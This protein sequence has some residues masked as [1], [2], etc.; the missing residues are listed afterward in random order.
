MQT[1]KFIERQLSKYGLKNGSLNAAMTKQLRV[2]RNG[3]SE[4]GYI[5]ID[6]LEDPSRIEYDHFT[7]HY[8]TTV[9]SAI[10][11]MLRQG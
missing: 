9:K 10:Q 6:D 7:T 2:I 8:P 1:I 3:N 11:S 5:A 4:L